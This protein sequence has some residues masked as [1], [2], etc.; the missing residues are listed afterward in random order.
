MSAKGAASWQSR[1]QAVMASGTSELEYVALSKAVK[2][3]L[4]L[5]QVQD[6]MEP[7]MTIGAVD[8]SRTWKGP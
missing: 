3:V 1:M 7:S 2:E 6:F 8:G 5:R 4:I